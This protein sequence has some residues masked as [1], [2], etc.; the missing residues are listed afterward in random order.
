MNRKLESSLSFVNMFPTIP[1]DDVAVAYSEDL[2]TAGA[3][4][5]SGTMAKP[6]DLGELSGLS[7]IEVS[8]IT[9]KHGML[10]PFG[11][12]FRVSKKDLE[13]GQVIDDLTRG[14]GRATYGIA[15]KI[16]SGVLTKI[17]NASNDITEPYQDRAGS[18]WTAWSEDGAK[19]LSDILQMVEAMDIEGLS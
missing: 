15:S 18:I 9:Q 10:R 6:L 4:I 19:P 16:N 2:T 13:R 11:Y 14:V 17:K 1:T 12:E 8:P 5:T 3:D 7:E